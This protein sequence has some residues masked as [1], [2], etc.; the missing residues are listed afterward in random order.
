MVDQNTNKNYHFLNKDSC[1][2]S[3]NPIAQFSPQIG[4]SVGN[5]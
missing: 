4:K 3:N 1:Y 5:K 2:N